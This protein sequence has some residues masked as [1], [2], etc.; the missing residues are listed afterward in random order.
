MKST[1]VSR[2]LRVASVVI[3]A[4]LVWLG[5]AGVLRAQS[6]VGAARDYY[7]RYAGR[8]LHEYAE[9]LSLP[10]RASDTDDIRRNAEWLRDALAARGVEAE[11]LEVEGAP[12]V[13]YG[14]MYAPGP[15]EGRRT[16]G[17]Y[18]H[19]DGQP[20]VPDKWA[21]SP[22]EPTLYTS[23]IEAG[24]EPRPFPTDGEAIDPEWR[25]YARSAADDK[26]PFMA[27]LTA[28]DAMR[29]FG[30]PLQS[31]VVFLLEGEEEAGSRHLGDY[32][33]R[34]A[35][36]LQA[37]VWLIF[38][39]PTHQSGRPQLV[40]G[41]R[42]VTG[43]DI[44]VY[45]A[46][47]YLHSGHYGNWAPNPAM[48]LAQLL[49][50]MKDET[51][52]VTIDG[53]YDSVIPPGPAVEQ[54]AKTIPDIDDQLRRDFGLAASE[55]G[56]APYLE[57][58]MVPSLNVRGFVSGA[59]GAQGRNVIPSTAEVSIDIRLVAGNDPA[60][61]LDKVEAH[62]R[63]QGYY[64]VGAEPTPEERLAHEK[65]ARVDRRRGYRATRTAMNLPV[66]EWVERCAR[67]AVGD[68]LILMPTMGGSLPLYLF[69]EKLEQPIVIVP[70]VNYDNNQHGPN[71]NLRL[72][73]LEYGVS[74]IAS[75]LGA[76]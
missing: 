26:A 64:I 53:F 71:E 61:M 14:V 10:N 22:W 11:L 65:I 52:N 23:A 39:G 75:I 55:A 25:L 4:A 5:G 29:Q 50:S 49:S 32:M 18:A 30:I 47:R 27:L 21:Q 72:G 66:V 41:V 17:F 57:R 24:G 31:N 60:D 67:E 59:V 28:L 46:N 8:I 16:I 15:P 69:E 73:N 63:G 51:G 54:A 13:V 43:L 44:T 19:Y 7:A 34:Y 38:D 68:E 9:F 1:I 48:M 45:G 42:G 33:D 36:R 20:V 76:E 6:P 56:N 12:P 35:D 2:P 62:I 37:D 70:I 40:F 3:A 58:L 74:L